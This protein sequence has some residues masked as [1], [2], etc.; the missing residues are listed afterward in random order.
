[1]RLFLLT[2]SLLACFGLQATEYKWLKK[3]NDKLRFAVAYALESGWQLDLFEQKEGDFQQR[4]SSKRF[5]SLSL[6]EEQ[7]KD[8]SRTESINYKV[9]EDADP[10][11][12][13]RLWKATETWSMKWEQRYAQWIQDNLTTDF[14]IEHG[15]ETDCADVIIGLRWIFSRIYK[16]PAANTM[17]GSDK[18]FSNEDM[19]RS[20]K[21]LPTNEIWHKDKLFMTALD[22]LMNNTYTHSVWKDS[23]PITISKKTLLEGTFFLN[24]EDVSGHVR[25]VAQ[26][27]FSSLTEIPLIMRASTVPRGLRRL[28]EEVFLNFERPTITN[29]GF[30]AMRWAVKD[31]RDFEL[32][33]EKSHSSYGLNQY[34]DD[35][36]GEGE[37]FALGVFKAVRPD[38]SKEIL[39][40]AGLSDILET[41][42]FRKSVVMEGYEACQIVDCS[43]G[44]AAYDAYS[45]PS[46]D[47]KIRKLF[48]SLDQLVESLVPVFPKMRE[49][50]L[51]ALKKAEFTV[52]GTTINMNQAR[53]L[54]EEAQVSFDPRDALNARWTITTE[55]MAELMHSRLTELFKS[56]E[57]RVN[58][59]VACEKN[60][61]P[62][63][64]WYWDANTYELDQ[65]IAQHNY[66]MRNFCQKFPSENCQNDLA[67]D[68]NGKTIKAGGLEMTLLGW[69][70]RIPFFNSDPRAAKNFSWGEAL[71]ASFHLPSFNKI[72]LTESLIAVL[73][74]KTAYD[75]IKQS[76]LEF[77]KNE[78]LTLNKEGLGLIKIEDELYPVNSSA[79]LGE[80]VQ[81][82]ID[83]KISTSYWEGAFSVLIAKD[84]KSLIA[85]ERRDDSILVNLEK[86]AEVEVLGKK[87]FFLS[88]A[89][90]LYYILTKEGLKEFDLGAK[91]LWSQVYKGS[92]DKEAII[93]GINSDNEAVELI[94]NLVSGEVNSVLTEGREFLTYL[95]DGLWVY[96]EN[97]QMLRVGDI[98]G[99]K[100]LYEAEADYVN[101]Q[102][103]YVTLREDNKLKAYKLGVE[104]KELALPMDSFL[105]G[106]SGETLGIEI[107]GMVHLM[108]QSGARYG[109]LSPGIF[110]KALGRWSSFE[111][112]G[113]HG[114]SQGRGGFMLSPTTGVQ[115]PALTF[116]RS[117]HHK[118]D[119]TGKHLKLDRMRELKR[120]V[121]IQT[122]PGSYTWLDR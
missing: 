46:R 106:T 1:M 26:T 31:G 55:G 48:K 111:N 109:A 24:L 6:I 61:F 17:A 11:R 67:I 9:Y 14:F 28:S 8:Y 56:R 53:Y 98:L 87:I 121:L 58:E 22:Y 71:G 38:F 117:I 68:L 12:N 89:S 120:G 40:N 80:P 84:M 29:S 25:I 82:S 79:K 122:Y 27:N 4:I 63:G 74:N 20:W 99:S 33:S 101:H 13:K 66:L 15:I 119:G 116:Q 114:S 103:T 60:C 54:F 36:I 75:L 95:A 83:Q 107:D 10:A 5:K 76:R 91:R 3:E 47:S 88:G 44:T 110:V 21:K 100:V 90:N 59:R 105:S 32:K 30:R 41:L 78:F 108:D 49:R 52:L 94:F 97:A 39:I 16:L 51:E 18:I 70:D 104:F 23:Y 37:S 19:L 69:N 93:S 43:P 35:F 92:S 64:N 57:S 72:E 2:I 86:K 34:D 112:D 50:W 65:S 81:L 45:T 42:E 62:K 85:I 115:V 73:D 113:S 7:L 77:P 102:G 96:K 118:D